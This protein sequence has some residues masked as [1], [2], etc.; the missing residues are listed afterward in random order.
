MNTTWK[1]NV[2]NVLSSIA[3]RGK[4]IGHF[5]IT[6]RTAV[7]KVAI[8]IAAIFVVAA[9]VPRCMNTESDGLPLE[10]TLA[11]IEEVRPRGELYVC[12][13]VIE[14]YTV[15]RS[16]E[17]HLLWINEEHVCIQTMKQ[18]CSYTIDLDKVVYAA[19]D[20][21]RTI[22]VTL[23]APTYTASTQGASFLAD[24]NDYWA[25]HLPNTNAMKRAVAERIRQ[26]FDTPDNRRQASRYA[27][28]IIS[29][30]LNKLGYKVEF[31]RTLE[32]VD[33]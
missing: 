12:S 20:S 28:D 7:I 23:P 14:D 29:N 24:N 18:K 16:T 1:D 8:T 2:R 26:R 9:F 22:H 31:T 6:H 33:E 19:N 25:K 13:S 32:R 15:E 27:E 10:N 11:S 30:L 17:K 5:F 4:S 21:T 3:E